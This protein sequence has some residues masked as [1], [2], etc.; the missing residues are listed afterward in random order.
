[1]DE[2]PSLEPGEHACYDVIIVGGG[3]A[4]IG[5]AVG[6]KLANRQSKVLLLESSGCLGGAATLRNVVSFCGLYTCDENPKKVV[7]GAWDM[8]FPMLLELGSVAPRPTRHRGIFQAIDPEGLKICLDR[9]TE[10]LGID[11]RL[12]SKVHTALSVP[13]PR[14]CIVSLSTTCGSV[15]CTYHGKAFV[16][17]SG[18]AALTYISGASVRYGNHGRVNLGS[19]ASRLSG[20]TGGVRPTSE[21]WS[22]AIKE[23]KENDPALRRKIPKDASVLLDLPNCHDVVTFLG[24]AVC[25][26]NDPRSVSR[27]EKS[28]REQVWE[29]LRIL[30]KL[31]G[32]DKVYLVSTGPE[33]G[34]RESRHANSLRQLTRD[35]ITNSRK[36]NDVVAVGGWGME[37]HDDQSET[38]SSSLTIVPNGWFE[39]PLSCLQ[40]EDM[41]NLFIAGRCVDA[42]Q[43]AG[44]A[45]RVMGTAMATGQ[46]AGIA[47]S[48]TAQGALD[49][50]EVQS[51]LKAQGA[52]LN[53]Q[54]AIQ[55]VQVET[56]MP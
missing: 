11:V 27:A 21:M 47:A 6:A 36:F 18:D 9:L 7:G 30:R 49:V 40:S 19:I 10:E 13:E 39:I 4:G 52:V 46:A 8:L 41:A 50:H 16:D 42:D 38:W 35:D 53:A 34:I 33:F 31:P 54:E 44:S 28:A 1:M 15:T 43:Y 45:V 29:Y 20:F 2:Q 5:A 56:A 22:N 24:S 17:C 55:G 48:L 3:A 32:H 12:H 26:L 14:R 51:I 37:W 25:D 23:A